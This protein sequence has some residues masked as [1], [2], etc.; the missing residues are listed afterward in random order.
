MNRIIIL[1]SATIACTKTSIAPRVELCSLY[2]ETIMELVTITK[3]IDNLET[4]HNRHPGIMKGSDIYMFINTNVLCRIRRIIN[5]G[6]Q[7]NY[8][9]SRGKGIQET[10][11]EVAAKYH[12]ICIDISAVITNYCVSYQAKGTDICQK[13][14]S[15][16]AITQS[17]DIKWQSLVAPRGW[18][19]Q[20]A[21]FVPA[22]MAD[23]FHRKVANVVDLF[24]RTDKELSNFAK[25]VNLHMTI[26]IAR[27]L[28]FTMY[29]KTLSTRV[30]PIVISLKQMILTNIPK[31]DSRDT[32]VDQINSLADS[33]IWTCRGFIKLILS[34]VM[35][36][37][38]VNDNSKYPDELLTTS[39]WAVAEKFS[40][41]V[42]MMV[43][44]WRNMKDELFSHKM[45]IMKHM[46]GFW[47]IE[48]DLTRDKTHSILTEV[49]DLLHEVAIRINRD[50]S[51]RSSWM[52]ITETFADI[53]ETFQDTEFILENVRQEV[54]PD[55]IISRKG[56]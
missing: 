7:V 16:H 12:S 55:R 30:I 14:L 13:L 48:V 5:L 51:L 11:V 41:N 27:S 32:N 31:S 19:K 53:F 28:A 42:T 46:E 2:S 26:P 56:I 52:R 21:W 9:V 54:V 50:N 29:I 6:D 34:L 37:S 44:E 43:S 22:D 33:M 18:T 23:D 38:E 8:T 1:F 3:E 49:H 20:Q 25:F 24:E 10:M 36:L 45:V 4:A 35:V 15:F 40:V 47:S 17:R 39:A